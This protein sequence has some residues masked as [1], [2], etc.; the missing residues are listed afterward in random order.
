ML[1]SKSDNHSNK[2]S[3]S[4]N[5]KPYEI[6]DIYMRLPA[7]VDKAVII[8]GRAV[9]IY[10]SKDKRQT[11]DIDMVVKFRDG[12][13]ND[14]IKN[15]IIKN[16]F[17]YETGS[18]GKIKKLIDNKTG[19]SID[20]Y[21]SRSINNIELEDILNTAKTRHIG[22][23]LQVNVVHPALLILMKLESNRSKDQLDVKNIVTTLYGNGETFIRKEKATLSLYLDE[24][25]MQNLEIM[26][27]KL[28]LTKLYR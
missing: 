16:G 7:F 14:D 27:N 3:A 4:F 22:S 21:Y 24:Q 19:I 10:C 28:A 12:L 20:V 9:N 13:Q 25:A 18:N 15:E 1:R 2:Y 17:M 23:D 11:H 8:G 6:E 5:I 26:L